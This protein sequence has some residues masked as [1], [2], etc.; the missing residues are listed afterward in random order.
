[1]HDL[2]NPLHRQLGWGRRSKFFNQLFG[3][4]LR[5]AFPDFT[6]TNLGDCS[7]SN[8]PTQFFVETTSPRRFATVFP[9]ERSRPLDIKTAGR[10]DTDGGDDLRGG[11]VRVL[12]AQ[13]P[14][15]SPREFLRHV[16]HGMID[17]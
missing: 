14:D 11:E 8:G 17:A 15:A 7:R 3:R 2:L 16:G 5:M 6:D 13:S 9:D 12:L 10:S 1:V 4:E